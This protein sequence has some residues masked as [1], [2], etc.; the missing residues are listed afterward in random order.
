MKQLWLSVQIHAA[1][2]GRFIGINYD[3]ASH[4]CSPEADVQMPSELS[5]PES[6]SV[7]VWMPVSVSILRKGESAF[8]AGRVQDLHPRI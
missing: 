6:S 8:A 7:P 3:Y 1:P 2:S 5:F 4:P